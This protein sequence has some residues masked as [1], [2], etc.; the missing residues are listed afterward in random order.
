MHDI[1]HAKTCTQKNTSIDMVDI[2]FTPTALHV[3][4]IFDKVFVYAWHLTWKNLHPKKHINRHGRSWIYTI[5]LHVA[6]IFD[7][8]FVHF[9]LLICKNLHKKNTSIDMVEIE[10]TPTALHVTLRWHSKKK[11]SNVNWHLFF[12]FENIMW[13]LDL[14]LNVKRNLTYTLIV[15]APLRCTR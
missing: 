11:N 7:K 3:A 10:F 8:V 15:W 5:A 9:L 12:A 14:K 4:C 13:R 1:W 2:E 6:C